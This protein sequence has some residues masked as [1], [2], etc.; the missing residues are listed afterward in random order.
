[1]AED[2]E[3]HAL[4]CGMFSPRLESHRSVSSPP[5]RV[6]SCSIPLAASSVDRRTYSLT[7]SEALGANSWE[8]P[9]P[10]ATGVVEDERTVLTRTS[11]ASISFLE[12]NRVYCSIVLLQVQLVQEAVLASR[13]RSSVARIG[14]APIVSQT[15]RA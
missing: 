5:P 15:M 1:M 11:S 12:L 4:C 2:V 9:V 3:F 13:R 7:I 14:L 6:I 10:A 8:A